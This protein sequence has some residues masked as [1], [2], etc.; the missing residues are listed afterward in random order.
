VQDDRRL[1]CRSLKVA[2]G[3]GEAARLVKVATNS[4]EGYQQY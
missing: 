1:E 4:I 3:A 2:L